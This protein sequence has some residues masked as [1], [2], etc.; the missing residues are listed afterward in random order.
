LNY[1]KQGFPFELESIRDKR[2]FRRESVINEIEIQLENLQNIL[3]VGESGFSKTTVLMEI[4]CDYIDKGYWVLYNRGIDVN[5]CE[6]L[7]VFIE[8]L[9]KGGANV[10]VAVDDAHRIGSTPIFYIIDRLQN[11]VLWE[12][13]RFV[14]T[15]RL[16]DFDRLTEEGLIENDLYRDS[17]SKF[18]SNPDQIYKLNP[19][20]QID[21]KKFIQ[22]YGI[23]SK[24]LENLTRFDDISSSKYEEM[25]SLS[26]KELDEISKQVHE[27]TKG[28]PVMLK[29]CILGE[30]L[31]KDVRDRYHRYL[32]GESKEMKTML[33]VSLLELADFVVTDELIR[34]MKAITV[35][36]RVLKNATLY[37]HSGVWSTIHRRWN[38]EFLKFLYKKS[39]GN[40]LYDDDIPFLESVKLIISTKDFGAI[41][42]VIR[43]LQSYTFF[44]VLGYNSTDVFSN[45]AILDSD[46]QLIYESIV[47]IAAQLLSNQEMEEI[48]I[49][50]A[51]GY[52]PRVP[53]SEGMPRVPDSEGSVYDSFSTSNKNLVNKAFEWFEKAK[54]YQPDS[55]LAWV[56]AGEFF[57][58]CYLW[59]TALYYFEGALERSP[60]DPNLGRRISDIKQKIIFYQKY[61]SYFTKKF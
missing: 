28:N 22:L 18:V 43:A 37:T 23:S 42:S 51:E 53:G 31:E 55:H 58:A 4:I 38:I 10:M 20:N 8:S 45:S 40:L 17:L 13:L 46:L 57:D 30:G 49:E 54:I 33:A 39:D 59:Q 24:W 12:K 29:F 6:G 35:A 1:W 56:R 41:F 7:R 2:E 26:N 3:I 11:Y 44:I 47:E 14:L 9:L 16:P 48:C 61:R 50:I 52:M 60:R 5:N 34:K 15:A 32:R 25:H 36:N 21:V 19:F 27:L